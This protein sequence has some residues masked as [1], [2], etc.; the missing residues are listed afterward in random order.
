M[1]NSPVV[2]YDTGKVKIGCRYTPPP[3]VVDI[4]PHA[5]LIQRAL[6]NQRLSFVE[7]VMWKLTGE[8]R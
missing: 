4:G 8:L 5:E 7:W 1:V 3:R 6:L 2:P